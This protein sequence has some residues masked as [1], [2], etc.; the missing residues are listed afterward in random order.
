MDGEYKI[1]IL[2]DEKVLERVVMV[3]QH[4]KCIDA[5]DL[6]TFKWLKWKILCYIYF[7]TIKKLFKKNQLAHLR[8]E[9]VSSSTS[10]LAQCS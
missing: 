10:I 2:D 4:C 8:E 1:S 3:T 6:H 7:T 5:T 9:A